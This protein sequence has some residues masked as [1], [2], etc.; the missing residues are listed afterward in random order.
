MLMASTMFG[1]QEPNVIV[2]FTDDLG[3]ADLS[4]MGM[5]PDVKTPNLDR[6]AAE[7]V[8]FTNGYVTAPQCGPS[9]VGLLTGY[10][11]GRLGYDTNGD[12]PVSLDVGATACE[13]AGLDRSDELDGVNLM[14]LLKD[15]QSLPDRTLYWRFWGQTAIRRGDWK[16]L[17]MGNQQSFLFNVAEDKAEQN[18]LLQSNP[19]VAADL[20][21]QLK[22]WAS[23]LQPP[24]IP[25]E[26]G[27]T[28]EV[29]FY[30][31]FFDVP[32]PEKYQP[33]QNPFK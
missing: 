19:D 30:E 14:P 24:G 27:N 28:E 20:Q 6:L 9:R 12:G 13:L 1:A 2:I 33:Q 25:D 5:E 8:R 29:F 7:G 31:H 11:Q 23:E 18:N 21:K 10:Y 22:T 4:C 17:K 15:G 16:F 3:Y 26:V 32:L